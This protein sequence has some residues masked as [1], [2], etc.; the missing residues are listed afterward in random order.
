MIDGVP[1]KIDNAGR[2]CGVRGEF[3]RW[4]RGNRVHECAHHFCWCAVSTRDCSGVARGQLP[5]GAARRGAP[6]FCQNFLKFI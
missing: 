4:R 2:K 1:P 5:P 6:K 3:K